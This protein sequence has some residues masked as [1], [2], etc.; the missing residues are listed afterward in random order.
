[1]LQIEQ[2]GIFELAIQKIKNEEENKQQ[3]IKFL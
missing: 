3:A 2:G 1:M